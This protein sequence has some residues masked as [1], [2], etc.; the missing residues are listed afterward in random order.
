MG[1]LL[2]RT[3][4][5][6]SLLPLVALG[7]SACVP[8]AVNSTTSGPTTGTATSLV[9]ITTTSVETTTT[10][11]DTTTEATV[12]STSTTRAPLP[13]YEIFE[14]EDVSFLGAVRYVA[15]VVT[16]PGV[17]ADQLTQ[18]AQAISQAVRL[19]TPYQALSVGFYDYTEY[20][21][22]GFVMGRV[23]FAPYGDWSRANEVELGDYST[24]DNTS[25]LREKD[26]SQRPT[27]E[28]VTLW[29]RWEAVINELDPDLT[30]DD[31]LALEMEAYEAVAKESDLPVDAVEEA[32]L[33][34]AFWPF[35]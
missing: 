26:W 30:R 35:S 32:V 8:S 4:A 1:S 27:Q 24:F 9:E 6:W 15:H 14:F 17:S 16:E 5:T 23:E 10:F 29:R 2:R 28:E 13:S 18:F 21:G 12:T 20:L 19:E 31:V 25:F 22:F 33:N 34:A 3:R 11:A 7:L